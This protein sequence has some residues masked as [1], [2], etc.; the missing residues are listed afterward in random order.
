LDQVLA[1]INNL[2]YLQPDPLVLRNTH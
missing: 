1:T 2:V